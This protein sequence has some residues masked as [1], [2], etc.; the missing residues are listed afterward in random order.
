MNDSDKRNLQTI[1][2]DKA[3]DHRGVATDS[4]A[5]YD[6]APCDPGHYSGV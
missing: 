2:G 4:L 6:Y 5:K 1:Y 3:T